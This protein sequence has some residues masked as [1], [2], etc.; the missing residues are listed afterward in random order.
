MPISLF[1]STFCVC[2]CVC[3]CVC[4]MS[5][6][7]FVFVQQWNVG[8]LSHCPLRKWKHLRT[9]HSY[10]ILSDSLLSAFWEQSCCGLEVEHCSLVSCS[11]ASWLFRHTFLMALAANLP[12][13]TTPP[14]HYPPSFPHS[15]RA[16]KGYK[17]DI[18]GGPGGV[19]KCHTTC[20]RRCLACS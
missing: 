20:W 7:T 17:E 11:L 3:V 12:G 13:H 1:L 8:V 16:T 9:S 18:V 19:R 10:C 5:L 4:K 2:T 6:L 15:P 14:P